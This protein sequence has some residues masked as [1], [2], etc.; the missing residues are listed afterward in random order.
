MKLKIIVLA[1][2]LMSISACSSKNY[3]E[4]KNLCSNMPESYINENLENVYRNLNSVYI[5]EDGKF[6]DYSMGLITRRER[7]DFIEVK[8]KNN[9][10]GFNGETG[11]YRVYRDYSFGN[12]TKQY[13]PYSGFENKFQNSKGMFCITLRK[14]TEPT[15]II[16]TK[17][18]SNLLNS[19]VRYSNIIISINNKIFINKEYGSFFYQN[20]MEGCST[21]DKVSKIIDN[22]FKS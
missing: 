18:S 5:I 1:I 7:W 8:M 9:V 17:F 22:D 12:C 13:M 14:I 16:K 19:N 3:R 2:S 21:K 10:S 15:S 4:Y 6:I 20:T 11:L